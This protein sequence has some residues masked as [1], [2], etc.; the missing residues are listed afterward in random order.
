MVLTVANSC[1]VCDEAYNLLE[2]KPLLLPCSHSFCKYCIEH[3]TTKSCPVCRECFQGHSVDQLPFIRQLAEPADKLIN[4]FGPQSADNKNV[5]LIHKEEIVVL[6][7]I[8]CKMAICTHCLIE[9]HKSCDWIEICQ[10]KGELILKIRESF[11]KAQIHIPD[12]YTAAIAKNNSMLAT[13]R[14]CIQDLLI[15]EKNALSVGERL[16]AQKEDAKINLALLEDSIQ[17]LNIFESS[18]EKLDSALSTVVSFNLLPKLPSMS[19]P[20]LPHLVLPEMH[21][22]ELEDFVIS[23]ELANGYSGEPT[24]SNTNELEDGNTDEPASGITDQSADG[25]SGELADAN[26]DEPAD[27]NADELADGNTDESAVGNTDEPADGNADEPMDGNTGASAVGNNDE[28]ADGNTE[29]PA[30][31]NTE[32]PSD[33]NTGEPAD[34]NIDEPV[35]GNTG[36][37]VVSNT[38]E[39][40]DGNTDEPADGNT[41]KPEDTVSEHEDIVSECDDTES[42]FEETELDYELFMSAL[43]NALCGYQGNDCDTTD[44][45]SVLTCEDSDTTGSSSE[46][47][48]D[49]DNLVTLALD[50]ISESLVNSSESPDTALESLDNC[51]GTAAPSDLADYDLG[52]VV[53]VYSEL[54]ENGFSSNSGEPTGTDASDMDSDICHYGE[55]H[56]DISVGLSPLSSM[57]V[58]PTYCCSF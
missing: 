36:E 28:P 33:G 58:I 35:D 34:G 24:E 15:F 41:G 8:T 47:A 44:N 14:G 50:I 53:D 7:C 6:W 17:N 43:V 25:N 26:T 20:R 45:V 48:S 16:S 5:C 40:A 12:I 51:S 52:L 56:S 22:G 13:V 46:D 4:K 9:T 2:R 27:G 30:E 10:H 39:P 55:H 49:A 38:N 42:E 23:N 37:A 29:E 19:M 57:V 32:E 54:Q 31:G 1:C 18:I 21:S 3:L 11:L